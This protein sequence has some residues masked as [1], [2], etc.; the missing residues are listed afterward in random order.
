MQITSPPGKPQTLR[1]VAYDTPNLETCGMYIEGL[2]LEQ[3]HDMLG[4]WNGVY[5]FAD[6][7]GIDVSSAV[8]NWPSLP[9]ALRP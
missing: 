8:P 7:K 1:A 9:A 5:V 4:L 6:A 2:R 3:H